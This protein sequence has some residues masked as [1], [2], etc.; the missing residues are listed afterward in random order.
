MKS[1]AE[2]GNQTDSKAV[3]NDLAFET[4]S[5]E[6]IAIHN[7]KRPEGILQRKWLGLINSS[8][9]TSESTGLSQY[10]PPS[11][12]QTKKEERADSNQNE[13]VVQLATGLA[14]ADV[15]KLFASAKNAQGGWM[16]LTQSGRISAIMEPLNE[17]LATA[18]VGRPVATVVKKKGPTEYASF[19]EKSWTIEL[20]EDFFSIEMNK[21]VMGQFINTLYHEA[22]HAE[23]YYRVVRLLAGKGILRAAI[24]EKTEINAAAVDSAM[25]SPMEIPD[26]NPSLE[27]IETNAWYHSFFGEKSVDRRETIREFKKSGLDILQLEGQL[28]ALN[29]TL[30]NEKSDK[31]MAVMEI[32]FLMN[33]LRNEFKEAQEL[34]NGIIEDGPEKNEATV[35]ANEIKA[36]FNSQAQLKKDALQRYMVIAQQLIDQRN[37]MNIDMGHLQGL[38]DDAWQAYKN[39]PEEADAWAIG[40]ALEELYKRN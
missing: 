30:D 21:E 17:I 7:D 38:R 12:A 16:I 6:T 8:G 9:Q 26:S 3:A 11:L 27:F 39:L 25:G 4:Q 15:S 19:D 13:N 40:D 20:N 31:D 34:V 37:S 32:G 2:K 22:R 14:A 29:I 35:K 5:D 18:G 28:L 1:N 23:Q 24:L 10:M 36:R 33:D